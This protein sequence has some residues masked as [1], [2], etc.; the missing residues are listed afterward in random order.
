MARNETLYTMHALLK[1]PEDRT[2]VSPFYAPKPFVAKEITESLAAEKAA[3]TI[4]MLARGVTDEIIDDP[5][6]R[7]AAY[8]VE[9]NNQEEKP[10]TELPLEEVQEQT[11]LDPKL[12][13]GLGVLKNIFSVKDNAVIF[14]YGPQVGKEVQIIISEQTAAAD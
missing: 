3:G 14:P 12:L 4:E 9:K 1:K 8:F 10:V 2:P 6:T 11:G 5:I 13:E 7:V